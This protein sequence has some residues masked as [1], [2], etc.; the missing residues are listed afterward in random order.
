MVGHLDV[1]SHTESREESRDV[2]LEALLEPD[3]RHAIETWLDVLRPD[4]PV[5]HVP[6][7]MGEGVHRED[8]LVLDA[9]PVGGE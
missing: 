2:L 6:T 5:R 4:D 9:E 7:G 1:V 8:P 3:E